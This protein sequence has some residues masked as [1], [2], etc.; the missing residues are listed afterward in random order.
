ML[1]RQCNTEQKSDS[2]KIIFL[3]DQLNQKA[4][5]IQQLEAL[6]FNYMHCQILPASCCQQAVDLLSENTDTA[7]II[8]ALGS[9]EN[10]VSELNQ[11]INRQQYPALCV[12]GVT[13]NNKTQQHLLSTMQVDLVAENINRDCLMPI[14]FAGLKR[15]HDSQLLQISQT[16]LYTMSQIEDGC[17]GNTYL[18]ELAAGIANLLGTHF[19]IIGETDPA[20][21]T[22]V[23]TRVVWIN[24]E[25]KDNFT[26]LRS[27]TPC[28]R[29]L[30]CRR[31]LTY[32]HDVVKKFPD[33]QILIDM[34]ID[35]YM[36]TAI[37]LPSGDLIGIL[38]TL[39]QSEMINHQMYEP[40]LEFFASRIGVEMQ[41]QRAQDKMQQINDELE[42]KVE[43]RTR[44]LKASHAE[45][46]QVAH[47]AGMADIA[48]G[49]LHNVGNIFNSMSVAAQAMKQDLAQS[50]L[51]RLKDTSDLIN[52]NKNNLAEY[53]TTDEKGQQIPQYIEMLSKK[54]N[55]EMQ[56][57]TSNLDTLLDSGYMIKEVIHNQLDFAKLSAFEEESDVQ[58]LVDKVLLVQKAFMDKMHISIEKQYEDI[59]HIQLQRNKFVH[60][61]TN[62]FKNACEAMDVMPASERK[63]F[64]SIHRANDDQVNIC[65]GD[66][67]PGLSDENKQKIFSLG[68]STKKDGHGIGLHVSYNYMQ[69]M[70]GDISVTSNDLHLGTKFTLTLPACK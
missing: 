8:L 51:S 41:R 1:V 27:G 10:T 17:A 30:E 62:L 28:E 12:I 31:V 20:D 29:V 54:L 55:G 45:L 11:L 32:P 58:K 33:D 50:K 59:P 22:I 14:L 4:H 7:I 16:L 57:F 52:E 44:E 25:Y 67:G 70:G 23:N 24:G 68:Y 36:G 65:I 35:S 5:V 56:Q 9:L 39:D 64:I 40:V 61:L 60:V 46:L 2:W 38:I 43:L 42:A 66:S 63:I 26:Y 19:V 49:V 53:L 34:G 6:E 47:Q 18:K 69:E 3:A 15:F 21:D 13:Q 37:Y 48:A